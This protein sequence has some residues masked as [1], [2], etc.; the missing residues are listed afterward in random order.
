MNF[1]R[2]LSPLRAARDLRGFLRLR[3]RYELGFMLAA[4][5][6]TMLIVFGV[7]KDSYFE[8]E[9]KRDIIYVQN[10]RA[11]RSLKEIIAQQ[12]IDQ[13]IRD[14]REAELRAKQEKRRREFQRIDNSL[15]EWGI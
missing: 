2:F 9:Y 12:K 1:L 13:A 14:K 10:W 4:F 7:A 15:T 3:H 11:D 5:V 6:T 8:K